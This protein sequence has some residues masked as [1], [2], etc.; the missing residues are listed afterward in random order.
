M[1]QS[2]GVLRYSPQLIGVENEK[3]WLI[4]HC[5][6][7]LGAYYRRLYHYATYR[8]RKLQ[9]PGWKD[10]VSVVRNEEPSE[11]FKRL[12]GKYEGREVEYQYKPGVKNNTLYYWLDVECEF[13]LDLRE[14]L[15][16]PRKPFYDLHVTIG[17]AV[18]TEK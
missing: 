8:C 16:L 12:W 11:E 17:N 14:E 3:W 1:F 5:D 15:G 7:E 6:A 18:N 9:Q 10:H 2:K 4:L 13:L